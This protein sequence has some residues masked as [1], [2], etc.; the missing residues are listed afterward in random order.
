MITLHGIA[1][2]FYFCIILCLNSRFFYNTK[3]LKTTKI[4]TFAPNQKAKSPKK[5]IEIK[6]K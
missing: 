2:R 1:L 6:K 3:N 4:T 5:H